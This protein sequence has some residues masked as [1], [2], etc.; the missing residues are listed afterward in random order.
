MATKSSL[1]SK[2][3][4]FVDSSTATAVELSGT[5]QMSTGVRNV[6]GWLKQASLEVQHANLKT[7]STMTDHISGTTPPLI[8]LHFNDVYNIEPRDQEPCGG[9]SR[10]ST[11]IKSFAHQQPMI[12]FS[13]D[14]FSPSIC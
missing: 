8:I 14:V 10:F 13:G 6:V 3:D 7:L 11:M 12:L 9:A 2:W 4:E 1:R 5:S